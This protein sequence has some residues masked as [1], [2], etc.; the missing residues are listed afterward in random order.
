[1]TL[2]ISENVGKNVTFEEGEKL[3]LFAGNGISHKYT[4]PQLENS[5]A[6]VKLRVIKKWDNGNSALLLCSQ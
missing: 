2:F 6:S 4:I 5:L 1:M 3:N